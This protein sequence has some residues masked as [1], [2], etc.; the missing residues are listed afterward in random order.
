M[1]E[2]L[3]F[4]GWRYNPEKVDIKKVVAPPYDVVTEEEKKFYKDLSPYNIFHL[5]LPEDLLTAKDNLN[6]WI[7]E[8]I[9]IR[10]KQPSLY[11]Y[12]IEFNYQ[13][14]PYLRKG[15]ILLVRLHRFEEGVIL[16]HE[17]VYKKVT[18]ERLNLLK[19]TCFQFSQV[20][21]L[22]EDPELETLKP[23]EKVP[24]YSVKHNEEHHRFYKVNSEDEIQK[25]LSFLKDKKIFIADGHHRYTTALEFKEEMEKIY[26]KDETKDYN[27]I[28]MYLCSLN[29]PNLLILPTH[30]VYCLNGIEDILEKL[31]TFLEFF[32]EPSCKNYVSTKDIFRSLDHKILFILREKPLLGKIKPEVLERIEGEDPVLSKVPLYNFLWILEKGLGITEEKLKEEGKV[33]F[34]SSSQEVFEMAKNNGLGVIFPS[35]S[36]E[37]FKQVALNFK[38]M[39]HK[40]TYFYPKILTGFV[41]HEVSGR[42][43]K[44]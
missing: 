15:W 29:D 16:P 24:L 28:V 1:P 3:P 22:Y 7:K 12:E 19:T 4:Y 36:T 38:R 10:E 17:K 31:R 21:G 40:A 35:L 8:G 43:V 41:L 37:S 11:F 14:N 44:P 9:L 2:C 39:P 18:Q 42:S 6:K 23:K 34:T 32:E 13:N 33:V 30:R 27:Y 5:E 25:I 26:G 20:F